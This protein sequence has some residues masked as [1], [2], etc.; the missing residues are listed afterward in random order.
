MKNINKCDIVNPV[1]LC[2][3]MNG[4]KQSPVQTSCQRIAS[5]R[6][7]SLALTVLLLAGCRTS[8]RSPGW[9]YFPDMAYSQAYETYSHNPNFSNGQSARQPV[10]GT[11]PRGA[12]PDNPNIDDAAYEQSYF[13]KKYY[14][15]TPDGYAAAGA[16]LKN[17]VELND[18]ALAEGKKVYDIYCMVCHGA[19]GDGQGSIVQGGAFP[20]VNPYSML[21]KDKTEGN[22]Y[23][24]ITYGKNLMGSYS[25]QVSPED[26]WN[27]IYYIQKL[28]GMG[29]FANSDQPQQA[30]DT[31]ASSVVK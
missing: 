25:S 5:L 3:E 26:R 30:A 7:A 28:S 16:G 13:F 27:V 4:L 17:P 10:A 1:P 12:L 29:R 18:H 31:T 8:E 15:E 11:I 14:P 24:A 6:L 9:A 20:P 21:L 22:F 23:H 19:K 2:G